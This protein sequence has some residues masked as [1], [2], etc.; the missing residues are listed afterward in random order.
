MRRR[1]SEP[2]LF[3]FQRENLMKPVITTTANKAAREVSSTSSKAPS[4]LKN[5]PPKGAKPTRKFFDRVLSTYWVMPDY[6]LQALR[7]KK[8]KW[9]TD[10][11]WA[12]WMSLIRLVEEEFPS[13]GR[14]RRRALLEGFRELRIAR[15]VK[16]PS[17]REEVLGTGGEPTIYMEIWRDVVASKGR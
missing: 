10:E 5:F 1:M 3:C 13:A 15:G 2:Q 14:C 4:T 7:A 11:A 9:Y 17:S 16:A 12:E 6:V 8:D